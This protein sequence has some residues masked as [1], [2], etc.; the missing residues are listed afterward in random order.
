MQPSDTSG[1]TDPNEGKSRNGYLTQVP[2]CI[3]GTSYNEE[4]TAN[5]VQREFEDYVD[6]SEFIVINVEEDTNAY[7]FTIQF[8]HENSEIAD[9]VTT[10]EGFCDEFVSIYGSDKTCTRC[11]DAVTYAT[12]TSS[13][14]YYY[15]YYLF[16]YIVAVII[17]FF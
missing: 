11:G 9:I 12:Y 3:S 10:A 17:S 4:T 8:D 13:A 15:G 7:N 16:I 14:N 1:G 6:E 2:Y 5:F